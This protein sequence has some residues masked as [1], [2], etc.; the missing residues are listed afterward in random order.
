MQ[1]G[2]LVFM[3]CKFIFLATIQDKKLEK[4]CKKSQKSKCNLT[5]KK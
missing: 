5:I 1:K 4:L 3:D 2:T